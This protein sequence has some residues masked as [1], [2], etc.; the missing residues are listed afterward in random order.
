VS[1]GSAAARSAFT[2]A[3]SAEAL[4]RELAALGRDFK[5]GRVGGPEYSAKVRAATTQMR[6]LGAR[7]NAEEELQ[8]AQASGTVFHAVGAG[9]A[10]V[11]ATGVTASVMSIA[12][13]HN[14]SASR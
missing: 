2:G 11:V 14:Q 3:G 1:D 13:S 12:S 6:S 9:G 4:R 8:L 10:G 5:Q 7:L